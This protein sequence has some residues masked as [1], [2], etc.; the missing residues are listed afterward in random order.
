METTT[1]DNDTLRRYAITNG[2]GGDGLLSD[3]TCLNSKNSR[4]N[5]IGRNR[6][7]YHVIS[8]KIQFYFDTA[9]FIG[10]SEATFQTKDGV[11]VTVPVG[12]D[13]FQVAFF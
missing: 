10:S 5:R 8:V 3:G 2:K 9:F 1:K 7:M 12:V 6:N 11:D 4:L 13:I